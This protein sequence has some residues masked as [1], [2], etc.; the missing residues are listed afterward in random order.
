MLC[1][2]PPNLIGRSGG[3]FLWKMQGIG[4][5]NINLV[6]MP[7]RRSRA[8]LRNHDFPG[9]YFFGTAAADTYAK[10]GA[11][12]H[13]AVA[14]VEQRLIAAERVGRLFVRLLAGTLKQLTEL[15]FPDVD[16]HQKTYM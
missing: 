16:K 13:P 8:W 4:R 6:W 10:L 9:E 15:G 1:V 11:V 7:S 5:D 2:A 12:G 3:R 14:H